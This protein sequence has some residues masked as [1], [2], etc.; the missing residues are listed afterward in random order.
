MSKQAVCF[1]LSLLVLGSVVPSSWAFAWTGEPICE[2]LP[3]SDDASVLCADF[4]AVWFMRLPQGTLAP[5]SSPVDAPPSSVSAVPSLSPTFGIIGRDSWVRQSVTYDYGV[6][7]NTDDGCIDVDPITTVSVELFRNDKCAVTI[8]NE[9][10][11]SCALCSEVDFPTYSADCTNLPFGRNV[12]CEPTQMQTGAAVHLFFP[13]TADAPA[14]QRSLPSVVPSP[15]PTLQ[16]TTAPPTRSPTMSPTKRPVP[17]KNC[18]KL[19]GCF[20]ENLSTRDKPAVKLNPKAAVNKYTLKSGTQFSI[21]CN[22]KGGGGSAFKKIDFEFDGRTRSDYFA[23]FYMGG[24]RGKTTIF[25]VDYLSN[26]C[27]KKEVTVIGK[28]WRG[29]TCFHEKFTLEAK[30]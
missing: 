7:Q 2:P 13:L 18:A 19:T 10:C 6:L 22:I 8:D 21:R 4:F 27:G 29:G 16:P 9:P 15:P 25:P 28:N 24:N 30:C 5:T 3:G 11:A 26:G 14:V 20:L 23:P 12:T 17:A 1:S